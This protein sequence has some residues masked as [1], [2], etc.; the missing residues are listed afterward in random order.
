[1]LSGNKGWMAF[2]LIEKVLS[3]NI[4]LIFKCPYVSKPGY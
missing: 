2:C 1:M 4:L 3:T